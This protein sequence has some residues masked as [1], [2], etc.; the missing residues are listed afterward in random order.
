[1][2]NYKHH[3]AWGSFWLLVTAGAVPLVN[4]CYIPLKK[5]PDEIDAYPEI[6][7]AFCWV[8]LGMLSVLVLA[9]AGRLAYAIYGW[10]AIHE[11]KIY[12]PKQIVDVIKEVVV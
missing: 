8:G 1:M 7:R 10:V 2:P 11:E 4:Y 9:N 12:G 3:I 6:W 5:F